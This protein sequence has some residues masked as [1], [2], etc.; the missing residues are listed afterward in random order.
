LLSLGSF[1]LACATPT[2]ITIDLST[3]ARCSDQAGQGDRLESTMIVAAPDLSGSA[4]DETTVTSQCAAGEATNGS[5]EIGTLVF[6]PSESNDARMLSVAVF[7]GVERPNGNTKTSEQC[8]DK[9]RDD[10]TIEGEPCI[11]ARRK[12]GFVDNS[13]IFL[14]IHLDTRCVGVQCGEDQTCANGKCVEASIACNEDTGQCD[15]PG[16]SG[17]GSTG[18]G[19][20]GATGT[21]A[22]GTG[23]S[24]SGGATGT[25]GT[26]VGGAGVSVGNTTGTTGTGNGGA[27]VSVGNT[28]GT[29]GTGTGG[30]GVG[31]STGTLTATTVGA[32]GGGGTPSTGSFIPTTGVGAGGSAN[33][34]SPASGTTLTA[35]TSTAMFGFLGTF[36]APG[37]K[38]RLRA[39]PEP[40][41][42]A[43]D[44]FA[45]S[46]VTS[47]AGASPV[48]FVLAGAD[49]ARAVVHRVTEGV[50][51]TRTTALAGA[52]WALGQQGQLAPEAPHSAAALRAPAVDGTGHAAGLVYDERTTTLALDAERIATFAGRFDALAITSDRRAWLGGDG[53]VAL[54]LDRGASLDL[55]GAD[56][57][58]RSVV[59]VDETAFVAG[60]GLLACRGATCEPVFLG[61]EHELA[62]FTSVSAARIDAARVE[63][64]LAGD[65][66]GVPVLLRVVVGAPDASMGRDAW[67]AEVVERVGT[68]GL[69]DELR[70]AWL[71]RAGRTIWVVS[72][73]GLFALWIG[74]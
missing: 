45:V 34:A 18:P 70:G 12:V 68:G 66:E 33:V 39:A 69:G 47:D 32:G 4:Y 41:L 62:R 56:V 22:S 72:E 8:R 43:S 54:E 65:T 60:D 23:A 27:S 9:Y 14:P 3:N 5:N 64:V 28:T 58:V 19:T 52:A 61:A 71:D 51:G 26:G 36:P 57:R 1:G 50:G 2:Q 31:T 29:T 30:S 37:V 67:V 48:V 49:R 46:G 40:L 63:L 11:L 42:V 15:D 17:G 24:G 16:G 53:V 74:K 73:R 13:K 10:G 25:T 21:G 59:A 6:V 7:A 20:G 44:L 38:S 55:V 35:G